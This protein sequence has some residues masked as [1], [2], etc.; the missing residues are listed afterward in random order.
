MANHTQKKLELPETNNKQRET[1]Y[2]NLERCEHK[3]NV[4]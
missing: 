1:F 4:K 2:N 3:K